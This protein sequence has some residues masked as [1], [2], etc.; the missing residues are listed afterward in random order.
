MQIK[1]NSRSA[2]S[3]LDKNNNISSVIVY[4]PGDYENIIS[5]EKKKKS[6]ESIITLTSGMKMIAVNEDFEVLWI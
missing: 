2:V 5:F 1:F 6:N 3:L 4:F